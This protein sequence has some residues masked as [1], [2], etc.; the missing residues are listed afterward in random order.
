MTNK[1]RIEGMGN[2]IKK[3]KTIESMKKVTGEIEA[4]ALYL[5]GKIQ[6]APKH[7][8]RK[9]KYLYGKSE[10]AAKMRRGFFARLNSGEIQVPYKRGSSPKS[11]KLEQ[12]W[13]IKIEKQGFRAVIGTGV[14]YRN[15]VQNE[16][17]Q[18]WYH[19]E[20]GWPTAQGVITKE[21]NFVIGRIT[22][23]L[24]REVQNGK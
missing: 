6:D 15:L 20:T 12:S 21:S 17:K 8:P 24:L 19:K 1:I 2:L 18:T 7:I 11:E 23:A 13:T 10:K 16:T 3:I 4:S 5:Q 22:N 14:K 9:N